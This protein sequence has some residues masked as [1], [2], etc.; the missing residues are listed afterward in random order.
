ML[1]ELDEFPLTEF[2][3]VL[4]LEEELLDEVEL[5]PVPDEDE[6]ELPPVPDEDDEPLPELEVVP[7]EPDVPEELF[8]E[9]LLLSVVVLFEVPVLFESTTPKLFPGCVLDVICEFAATCLP[10][11]MSDTFSKAEPASPLFAATGGV[12][13]PS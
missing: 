1:L 10:L 8:E 12:L 6:V 2:P 11:S 13:F 7:P 4:P 3:L 9:V 5:P